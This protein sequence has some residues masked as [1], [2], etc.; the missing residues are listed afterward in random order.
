[1]H[2][3]AFVAAPDPAGGAYSVPPNPLTG[4]GGGGEGKEK[5]KG[6]ERQGKGRKERKGKG[7]KIL[8]TALPGPRRSTYGRGQ[9][10]DLLFYRTDAIP[11]TQATVS[12]SNRI[13]TTLN[14]LK[15]HA[16]VRH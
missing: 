15:K 8:A 1:M 11:N 3:N 4:F 2:Q 10:L 6:D 14:E 7:A 5:G 12:D 9:P 13:Q 16:D